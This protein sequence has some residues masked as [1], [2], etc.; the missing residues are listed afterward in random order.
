MY[1]VQRKV[2]LCKYQ[3]ATFS[4]DTLNAERNEHKWNE[5]V[6]PFRFHSYNCP[7]LLMYTLSKP[8]PTYKLYIMYGASVL[9]EWMNLNHMQKWIS[10]E[11]RLKHIAVSSVTSFKWFRFFY[12]LHCLSWGKTM[13]FNTATS[14]QF[15]RIH[16]MNP[17]SFF[18]SRK[19][20]TPLN[21]ANAFILFKLFAFFSTGIKLYSWIRSKYGN[22]KKKQ[23][24]LSSAKLKIYSPSHFRLL[25]GI[26]YTQWK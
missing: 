21:N 4:A 1:S 20:G 2:S 7:P 11:S 13:A 12:F 9:I 16:G 10:T 23:R 25:N 24:F 18:F 8:K 15:N 3:V 26:Y 5:N 14:I 17:H 19:K 6:K 22:C